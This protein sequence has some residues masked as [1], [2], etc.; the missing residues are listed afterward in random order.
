MSTDLIRSVSRG[1][2]GVIVFLDEIVL[3]GFMMANLG[4]PCPDLLPKGVLNASSRTDLQD[5]RIQDSLHLAMFRQQFLDDGSE[6]RLFLQDWRHV[7]AFLFELE[8]LD[9]VRAQPLQ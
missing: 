4:D 5:E 2:T 3:A 1:A 9:E 7:A 6:P 8:V